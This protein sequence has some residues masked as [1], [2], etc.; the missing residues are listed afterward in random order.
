MDKIDRFHSL[1]NKVQVLF[2]YIERIGIE[3]DVIVYAF[4]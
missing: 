1:D 3:L 2:I 4:K